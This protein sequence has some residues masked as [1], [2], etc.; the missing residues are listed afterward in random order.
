[1]LSSDRTS[2][3]RLSDFRSSRREEGKKEYLG[4]G[5]VLDCTLEFLYFVP[6]DFASWRVVC[7]SIRRF[8]RRLDPSPCC[9]ANEDLSRYYRSYIHCSLRGSFVLSAFLIFCDC[10]PATTISRT[11]TPGSVLGISSRGRDASRPVRQR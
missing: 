9:Y 10:C 5:L 7:I 11:L 6:E 3:D 1:M 8:K 4:I 2:V